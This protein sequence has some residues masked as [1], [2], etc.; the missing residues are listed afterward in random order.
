M[1]S[2]R[3]STTSPISLVKMSSASARSSI[4]T[5][6]EGAGFRVKRGFPKLFGVHLAQTL[7]ALERKALFPFGKDRLQQIGWPMDRLFAVFPDK[8][9]RAPVDFGMLPAY[10]R[11]TPRL[12]RPQ[13]RAIQRAQ[14]LDPAQN[15]GQ[16]DAVILSDAALPAAFILNSHW[17]S[18]WATC[19]PQLQISISASRIEGTGQRGLFQIGRG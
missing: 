9:G 3:G 1:K 2:R 7:V 13:Y 10:L 5:L 8:T 6:Q 4:L 14:F 16:A 12:S 18:R 17:S 19:W 11:Q 15:T